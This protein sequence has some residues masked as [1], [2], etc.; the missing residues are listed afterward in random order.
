MQLSGGQKAR[1][2]LARAIYADADVVCLDDVLSAVD[3]HTARFIW[4][5]C[6]IEGFLKM[7]KTVILVSHQIQYLSRPE[8]DSVI[9]LR[10][11]Q[12]WLQGPWAE[13]AHSGDSF[14]SLVQAWGARRRWTGS[15]SCGNQHREKV[16]SLKYLYLKSY[17]SYKSSSWTPRM[18]R[19]LELRFGGL[20]WSED[21]SV[22]YPTCARSHEWSS[23]T[24]NRLNQRRCH[25][26]AWFQGVYWVMRVMGVTGVMWVMVINFLKPSFHCQI[27]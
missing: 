12:I 15:W 23:W 4:Q 17:K 18:S 7:K 11:G 13:L 26:V 19:C 3:A 16:T 25:F 2:A 20:G 9:M 5:K 6:F 8:V 21:W 22:A 24:T 14:L 10:D 27:A 1:V